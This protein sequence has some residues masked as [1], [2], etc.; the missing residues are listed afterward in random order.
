VRLFALFFIKSRFFGDKSVP[1]HLF[2]CFFI[3][4][5][6]MLLQFV[7][8]GIITGILY[9]LS[10][11]G[12]A[13][14]YNTTRIFHIAAAAL[15]MAAA[16]VFFFA[17]HT[18]T[19]PLWTSAITA[20][21]CTA[22]LSLLCEWLIYKPLYN[23]QSSLNV[24]MISSIGVMIILINTIALIFGNE[25]KVIDNSIQKVFTFGEIIVTRPQ[26]LQL[27]SGILLIVLFMSFLKFTKFGLK[28]RALSNDSVLFEVS[29]NS[30]TTVRNLVFILSGIFLAAGS[31]LTAYD[32]GMDPHIGM[33]ILINAMVAMIIGGIGRFN[34]CIL[35]GLL[36]GVLQALV[37]YQFSA[38]WQN[39]ITFLALLLFLF[40]RPQGIIGYK[41]RMV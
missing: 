21:I 17:F 4:E 9:S 32:I 34:A 3:T 14:V 25:T 24:V 26:V 29:G 18:L 2:I 37:V 22:L 28:M 11:I 38:N 8:N 10:A 27:L 31:C 12:F 6:E 13:L 40:L 41:K 35:G 30:I 1:L 16:Y 23:K 7:V 39:A 15:Y 33:P 5:N 19:L 20:L 36:L